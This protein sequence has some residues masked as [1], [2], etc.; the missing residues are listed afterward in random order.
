[1]ED[2]LEVYALPYDPQIP[3]I[4]MDEQPFQR[5]SDKLKSILMRPGHIAK[6]DYEYV[7]EGTC[8]IFILLNRLLE[9]AR[10]C[11]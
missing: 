2:V 1:M 7:R 4:C 8:S 11:I 6:E 5:L 9:E 10:A 3:L